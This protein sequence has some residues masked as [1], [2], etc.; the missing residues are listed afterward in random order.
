MRL[1]R[2]PAVLLYSTAEIVHKSKKLKR[3][4]WTCFLSPCTAL[5]SPTLF[6][7]RKSNLVCQV[8]TTCKMSLPLS[9]TTTDLYFIIFPFS[10]S[11]GTMVSSALQGSHFSPIV[12]APT[13]LRPLRRVLP[14]RAAGIAVAVLRAKSNLAIHSENG[15]LKSDLLILLLY[16]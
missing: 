11:T 16:K 3:K 13:D 6:I 7:F 12:S 2:V 14:R 1:H 8:P 10:I 4:L 5:W 9:C 15:A